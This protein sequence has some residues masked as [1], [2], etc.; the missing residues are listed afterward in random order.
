MVLREQAGVATGPVQENHMTAQLAAFFAPGALYGK[1]DL[2][3]LEQLAYTVYMRYMTTHA[4]QSTLEPPVPLSADR[5]QD[6]VAAELQRLSRGAT[7]GTGQTT[8]TN[9]GADE[10]LGN[11]ILF[12]RDAFWYLEFASAI[13]EGDV[14]RVVEI[15]KVCC[16]T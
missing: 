6:L 9:L 16:K 12:M 10:M 2:N 4:Y 1:C 11:I 5:I 13:P 3:Q 15:M 14:G 7:T 8:G